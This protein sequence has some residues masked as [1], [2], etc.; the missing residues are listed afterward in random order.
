[1]NLCFPDL[2]VHYNKTDY[3]VYFPNG[4]EV[5]FV[6]LDEGPRTEKLLG[7]EFSTLYFNEASEINYTAIQ[8]VI[9]RLAEKNKLKKRIWLDF[10]PPTKRHWAYWLF[11]KHID[12]IDEVPVTNPQDYVSMLMNPKD[13]LDNID[14]EY[15]ELLA[16]MPEREKNRFLLGLYNDDSD[17]TVY[18]SFNRD[19]HVKP[20]LKRPGTIFAGMD[21]NISPMTAALFQYIDN[22]FYVFDE[23]F[24]DNSDTFKMCAE[25]KLRGYAGI[26]VLPDSTGRNRKTSG[27]SDFKILQDAGFTIESTHNPFVTDRVNNVNRLF[28]EDRIVID[29]KCKKLINDLEKVVW[30]ND[31]LDQSGSNKHLTHISD[32]LG[33]GCWKLDPFRSVMVKTHSQPR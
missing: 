23:V 7:L 12:P 31:D 6:G 16:K 15:L 25:L 3:I 5:H 27:L 11:E 19:M 18:Y 32:C 1:M 22:T 26:K 17:G 28:A 10:N 8:L 24:M 20:V 9:S 14:S 13:N 2:K 29:P 4:S 33:Y 30:K 21:F